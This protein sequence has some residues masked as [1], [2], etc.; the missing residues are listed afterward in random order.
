MLFIL[1]VSILSE[2]ITI[3]KTLA[4]E[5]SYEAE[6]DSLEFTLETQKAEHEPWSENIH[7]LFGR[8]RFRF[9]S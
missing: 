3:S 2:Q 5:K 8:T 4:P 9:T 6:G 1:Q 7:R